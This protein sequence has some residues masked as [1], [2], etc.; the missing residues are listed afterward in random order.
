MTSVDSLPS[1]GHLERPREDIKIMDAGFFAE[2][3]ITSVQQRDCKRCRSRHSCEN[4]NIFRLRSASN[5]LL[6]LFIALDLLFLFFFLRTLFLTFFLI[7]SSAFVAHALLL[8]M[9]C[10]AVDASLL[11]C[12]LVRLSM[13]YVSIKIDGLVKIQKTRS[14]AS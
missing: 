12:T 1:L 13:L 10:A 5:F 6:W 2:V 11:R 4:D 9:S 7:F 8:A 14:Y 3:P